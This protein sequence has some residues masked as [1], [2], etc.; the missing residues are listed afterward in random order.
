[1]KPIFALLL[2]VSFP[3]FSFCQI[4]PTTCEA[5]DSVKMRYE[6]DAK[7]MAVDFMQ[8]ATSLQD[9]VLIPEHLIELNRN[10]P[11]TQRPRDSHDRKHLLDSVR[12]HCSARI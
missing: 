5:P 4:V 2:A 7:V 8:E 11:I 12:Y 10:S 3:F 6:L 1:M 9:S